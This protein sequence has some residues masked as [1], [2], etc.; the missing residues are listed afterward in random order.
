MK[1]PIKSINGEYHIHAN[2]RSWDRT[3]PL[4]SLYS[5]V[6]QTP[7][8]SLRVVAFNLEQQREIFHRDPFDAAGFPRLSE[9]LSELA[10]ATLSVE[11]CER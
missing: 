7:C 4:E 1:A 2:L 9:S 6:R 11:A 5:L 3:L 8:K 10:T